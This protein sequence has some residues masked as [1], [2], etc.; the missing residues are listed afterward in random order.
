M[1]CNDKA[2]KR[3]FGGKLEKSGGKT[4]VRERSD[5]SRVAVGARRE[6]YIEVPKKSCE[7]IN[8]EQ[9]SSTVFASRRG[10]GLELQTLIER[11]KRTPK[12]HPLKIP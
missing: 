10:A 8:P 9:A 4:R 7:V 1:Q 12:I 5:Q 2:G 3:G 6:K 11:P